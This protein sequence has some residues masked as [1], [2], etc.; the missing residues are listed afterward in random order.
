MKEMFETEKSAF[1]Q[2]TCSFHS[3]HNGLSPFQFVSSPK[4]GLFIPCL[5]LQEPY[6]LSPAPPP[7]FYPLPR[8]IKVQLLLLPPVPL[9]YLDD[10]HDPNLQRELKQD[11]RQEVSERVAH[12]VPTA[13]VLVIIYPPPPPPSFATLSLLQPSPDH[14]ALQLRIA[15][16][17]RDQDRHEGTDGGCSDME[18]HESEPL[19]RGE[20]EMLVVLGIGIVV[21]LYQGLEDS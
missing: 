1:D 2:S 15:H 11:D 8:S 10:S 3:L 21:S 18:H 16:L 17:V 13:N 20:Q 19:E 14:W 4:T 7:P 6:L 12:V 9:S 5:H